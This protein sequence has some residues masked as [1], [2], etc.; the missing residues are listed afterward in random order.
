MT[1]FS[2]FHAAKTIF[3]LKQQTSLLD[4]NKQKLP[5]QHSKPNVSKGAFTL[6]RQSP[7]R[8]TW[9][10]WKQRALSLLNDEM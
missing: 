4:V 2:L 1:H 8:L 6:G 7:V 10:L 5:K 3:T 9:A